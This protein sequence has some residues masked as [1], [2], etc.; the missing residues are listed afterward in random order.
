[1]RR[2][3]SR[4]RACPS[5]RWPEASGRPSAPSPRR[6]RTSCSGVL[7][8]QRIGDDRRPAHRWR[9]RLP[10][11]RDRPRA[12]WLE[13]LSSEH[14]P[15]RRARGAS[16]SSATGRGRS[17]SPSMSGRE[18]DEPLDA[19]SGLLR[20][21]DVVDH[22]EREGATARRPRP[23]SHEPG[24]PGPG[25]DAAPRGARS[26][27][28]RPSSDSR[29]RPGGGRGGHRRAPPSAIS[30]SSIKEGRQRDHRTDS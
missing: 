20:R 21:G 27:S 12:A 24:P 30:A 29:I 23:P 4:A 1:M 22:P 26:T 2:S 18:G 10:A 15:L 6:P 19:L 8:V 25:L 9:A 5:S 3:R 13:R 7:A 11:R 14:G 16:C 17:P 28:G